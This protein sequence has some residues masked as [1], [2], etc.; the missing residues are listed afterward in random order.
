MKYQQRVIGISSRGRGRFSSS[1][2]RQSQ[3]QPARRAPRRDGAAEMR[4]RGPNAARREAW[5]MALF[6]A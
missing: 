3:P 2:H 4:R 5:R 6:I 1:R